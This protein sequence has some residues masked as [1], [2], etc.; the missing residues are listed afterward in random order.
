MQ[1]SSHTTMPTG[2]MSPTRPQQQH[3]RET[4]A[5]QRDWQSQLSTPASPTSWCSWVTLPPGSHPFL[6]DI[7]RRYDLPDLPDLLPSDE[8]CLL[9]HL[10]QPNT[11]IRL[12]WWSILQLGSVL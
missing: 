1:L 8:H 12:P 6:V 2:H 5:T 4:Q 10:P 3:H 9:H 7:A 11:R